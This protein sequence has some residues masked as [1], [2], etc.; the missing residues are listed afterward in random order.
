MIDLIPKSV[1][2]T[3]TLDRCSSQFHSISRIQTSW[4]ERYCCTDRGEESEKNKVEEKQP[5]FR[6]TLWSLE[7]QESSP[8]RSARSWWLLL[9]Q[10]LSKESGEHSFGVAINLVSRYSQCEYFIGLKIQQHELFRDLSTFG[11]DILHT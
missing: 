10:I 8:M 11:K 6:G 2:M 5:Q 9:I 4:G 3:F 1:L 7:I